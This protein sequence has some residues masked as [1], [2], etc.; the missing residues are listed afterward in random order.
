MATGTTAETTVVALPLGIAAGTY[1]VTLVAN[2]IPS[3]VASYTI[4]TVGNAAPS[5]ATTASAASSTVTGTSVVMSVLGA[6]DA[7]EANLN[8]T[9]TAATSANTTQLPSFSGNGDNTVKS[10]TATFHQ[11]G[12]YTFKVTIGDAGGRS[13]ASSNVTVTVTATQ[14]SVTVTPDQASLGGGEMPWPNAEVV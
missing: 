11:I 10:K 7:G 13:V 1:S 12:T 6:D 9:W 3:P 8:Y 14:T 4:S 2:G 5:I